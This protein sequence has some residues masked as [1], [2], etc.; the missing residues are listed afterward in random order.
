ENRDSLFSS[1]LVH[2]VSDGATVSLAQLSSVVP[3]CH[4]A[5]HISRAPA[6]LSLL[7][8]H[9][10]V[11]PSRIEQLNCNPTTTKIALPPRGTLCRGK[12]VTL[13][14]LAFVSP[15]PSSPNSLEP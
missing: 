13:L 2:V 1:Y 6:R 9:L 5:Q 4:I 12:S 15:F 10:T 7:P 8:Q 11:P 14:P 3:P